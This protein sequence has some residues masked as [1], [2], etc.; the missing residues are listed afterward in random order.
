[1][2]K[3]FSL[4]SIA[5]TGVLAS[6]LTIAAHAQSA[7]S[8]DQHWYLGGG[9]GRTTASPNQGDYADLRAGA[10]TSTGRDNSV[11]WKAYGGVQFTPNWGLELGYANLGKY[12][13]SYSLPA[14]SSS[15]TGTNKLSAWSLAGVGTYAV[16]EVFSLHAKAGLALVRNEYSFSG[17][18]ASYAAGDNGS[19]RSTN[20]LLGFGAKYTIS[21]NFALRFDYENY[22]KVGKNTNNLTSLG[23]TGQARP[24]MLSA[25]VQ[26]MF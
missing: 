21:K 7:N 11:T 12:Q 4:A 2:K 18:G 8:T 23:A 24:A 14:T 26:Y 17:S 19:D 15:G 22:G 5:A 6:G 1:M 9:L 25:G 13:N 10:S 20:L 16:N 3:L